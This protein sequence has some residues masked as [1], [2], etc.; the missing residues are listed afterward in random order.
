MISPADRRRIGGEFELL[1]ADLA[2]AAT[3]SFGALPTLNGPHQV[4]L[5]T[6]RSALAAIARQTVRSNP[7]AT[8]WL[9]AYC[10]ESIASSFQAQRLKIRYYAVGAD[11]NRVE[12]DPLPGDLLLFIHYFGWLNLA[13]LK[14]VD[15]FRTAGVQLIEDCVQAALTAGIGSYGDHA[16]TSLRKLLPQPDGALLASRVS[17]PVEID[18]PDE[19]FIS[20]R[21]AGKLLRAHSPQAGTFLPLLEQSEARLADDHPRAMSWV[22]EQLLLRT[23]LAAVAQRRLE[24]FHYLFGNLV[25]SSGNLGIRPLMS[26]PAAGEVPL[27]CPVLVAG[28]RRDALRKHLAEREIYCPV[29]WPLKHLP[30]DQ[31][32]DEKELS[33]TLLTLPIDQRYERGDMTRILESLHTFSGDHPCPPLS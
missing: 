18:A 4:W 24:N 27:G 9:P 17:L 3:P 20:A 14:L 10:C 21:L 23:D 28:G 30:S 15:S 29:H 25:E 6:G 22:S 19:G 26:S 12:A 2:F 16:I 11:L 8:V 7:Q 1:P 33:A 13:A 31:F 32:K 5:D